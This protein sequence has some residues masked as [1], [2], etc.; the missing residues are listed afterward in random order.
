MDEMLLLE[1]EEKMDKSIDALK[2][3]LSTI[4]TGRVSPQVLDRISINYYGEDTPIKNLAGIQTPSA[5]QLLIR[6]FDP[7]SL[8][9]IQQAIGESDL[10]VNP[11]VDGQLI[12]LNFPA[13]TEERRNEFSKQARKFCEDSKIAIR[14]IRR[15]YNAIVKKD[16]TL[17]EDMASN[18]E[19]DIQKCT[20]KHIAMIDSVFAAKDKE[21]HTI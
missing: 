1:C 18:L 5:T 3:N 19:D 14:N 11:Q 13:L 20:D 6:P 17:S 7:T 12:R 16:K 10:G 21:L 8:K 9:A 4:R 2:A 15:D